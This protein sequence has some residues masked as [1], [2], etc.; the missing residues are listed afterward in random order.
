[1]IS[2]DV[3]EISSLAIVAAVGILGYQLYGLERRYTKDREK[4]AFDNA[5][6]IDAVSEGRVLIEQLKNEAAQLQQEKILAQNV[7]DQLSMMISEA[8]AEAENTERV[9]RELK[10][11]VKSANKTRSNILDVVNSV[12][13]LHR[14][15]QP[16]FEEKPSLK[17]STSRNKGSIRESGV[18]KLKSSTRYGGSDT[19]IVK[20]PLAK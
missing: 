2:F 1:M 4:Q 6:A 18:G 10:T 5:R 12:A 14:G 8:E 9:A 20:F 15:N 17:S 16:Q 11:V 7:G 19:N 13:E 3:S